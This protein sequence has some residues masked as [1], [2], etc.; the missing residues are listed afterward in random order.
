MAYIPTIVE[1]RIANDAVTSAKI[2]ADAVGASEIASDA[3]GS[4][5]IA[6]DA[7]GSAELADGSVD[8]NALQSGAVTEAK[9]GAGAV[10]AGKL[11]NGSVTTDKLAADAVTGDKIAAGAVGSSQIATGAVGSDEIASGAVGSDEIASGAVDTA[12]LADGAVTNGK[13]AADAVDGSKLADNA[14]GSEHIAAGAVDSS[15]LADGA[16]TSAKIADGAIMDAD[17]NA[18]AGI[19]LSKLATDP[20]DRANHTGTQTASTISDFDTQV[21]TNRLDQMAAPTGSVSLNSQKITS[22]ATP[23]ADGDA[24]TK[25]YVDTSSNTVLNAL[26]EAGRGLDVKA[27][28]RVASTG[29]LDLSAPGASIDGV[30]LNANA[31]AFPGDRVLVKNQTTAS[32]NGIYYFRGAAAAMVRAV[33][34]DSD[35]DVTAG[36]FTFVEEG[37]TH[38][39]QGWVLT[40]NNAITLGTTSLAFSQFSGAGAISAGDGLSK[41]GDQLDV[42]VG[43]GLEIS[44][45]DVAVDQTAIMDLSTAQSVDGSKTF[46]D[47]AFFNG[48]DNDG[49]SILGAGQRVKYQ[50]VTDHSVDLAADY[51][52]RV[53]SSA[54]SRVITLPDNHAAGDMI[55]LK[56]SGAN[57]VSV[58]STDLIDG[59]GSDFALG[60]DESFSFISDGT[61]W[62]V[63]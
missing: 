18:S 53:N 24:A 38:A 8:E 39:D 55:V 35:A 1:N 25:A 19:N 28:V 37:D 23:T 17:I 59:S 40:T 14:V 46:N 41:T 52:L 16:V 60:A 44:G 13:L 54:A 47:E 27:S 26:I 15:E 12:E 42:N 10:T 21:R 9:L 22:L 45:D 62:W 33:D 7:V 2:A 34:A 36:M 11:A 63:F 4:A 48:L 61:D 32:Q 31:G 43:F 50:L 3:V 58:T 49:L 56:R 57:G 30:T 29:N 5:E 20:L 51:F 6:A